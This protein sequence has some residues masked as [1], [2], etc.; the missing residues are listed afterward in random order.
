MAALDATGEKYTSSA[1]I[2]ITKDRNDKIMWLE[3][4]NETAGFEHILDHEI[5]FF[6]KGLSKEELPNY[7]MTAASQG[8]IVGMQGPKPIYEFLYR[9]STHRIALGV[10][11][12]GFIIAANPVSSTWK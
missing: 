8:R 6:N 9:G 7:I 2:A 11:D 5:Q 10:S 4:G 12:N 3:T 1:V